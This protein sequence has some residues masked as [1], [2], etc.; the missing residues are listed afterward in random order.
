MTRSSKKRLERHWVERAAKLLDCN[1][2]IR[3]ERECPDFIVSEGTHQFG[4]E[5]SEVFTGPQSEAGSEIRKREAATQKR[6]STLQREYEASMK[7]PLKVSFVGDMSPAN[8]RTVVPNLIK[9][10]LAS[11]SPGYYVVFDED[12]GLRVHV[13]REF[14][15]DWFYINDTAGFVDR[16]PE[17]IL[18]ER[19]KHKS[20]NLSRYRMFAGDDMRLLLVANR[21][22]NSGKLMFEQDPPSLDLRGFQKVYFF[23]HPESVI[24]FD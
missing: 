24:V 14:R 20:N 1:W 4:L 19:I 8:L 23:S 11:K 17:P 18:A 3:S 22:R 12:N 5:V 2:C 21:Y 10:D 16:N 6:I 7:V 15:D 13:K 9:E